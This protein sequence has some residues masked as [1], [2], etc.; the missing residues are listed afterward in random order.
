MMYEE[1]QY[2]KYSTTARISTAILKE[3]H[4]KADD[5]DSDN[6]GL[7]W[8]H[9]HETWMPE[10]DLVDASEGADKSQDFL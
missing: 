9:V 6:N 3:T 4:Q 1:W 2:S 8:V 7:E 10:E 5:D